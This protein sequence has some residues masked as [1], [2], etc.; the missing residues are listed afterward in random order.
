ML[1]RTMRAPWTSTACQVEIVGTQANQGSKEYWAVAG[2][3]NFTGNLEVPFGRRAHGRCRRGRLLTERRYCKGKHPVHGH[4]ET[5][6]AGRVGDSP[7]GA[8]PAIRASGNELVFLRAGH[9]F[10]LLERQC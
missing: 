4:S 2:R 6:V 5:R 1:N 8:I 10:S 9:S 3:C 7:S